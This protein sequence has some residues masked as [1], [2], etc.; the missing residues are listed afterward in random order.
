VIVPR[1]IVKLV[2][3]ERAEIGADAGEMLLVLQ[4]TLSFVP[5]ES[6]S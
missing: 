4:V 5:R 2:A 6:S 3:A 1:L